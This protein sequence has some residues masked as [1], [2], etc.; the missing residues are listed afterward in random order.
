MKMQQPERRIFSK[1]VRQQKPLRLASSLIQVTANLV[2]LLAASRRDGQVDRQEQE[3]II[4]R[5]QLWL[6][7]QRDGT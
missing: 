5:Q 6:L 3:Y 4:L 7:L 1:E 2:A